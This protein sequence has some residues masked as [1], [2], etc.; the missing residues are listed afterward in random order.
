MPAWGTLWATYRFRAA[1]A[2]DLAVGLTTRAIRTWLPPLAPWPLTLLD[3]AVERR[4]LPDAWGLG[5]V[6]TLAD[7]RLTPRVSYLAG[8]LSERGWW[9]YFPATLALK[10]PLT[11]LL[12]AALGI[13]TLIRKPRG[14]RVPAAAAPD[15]SARRWAAIL[16]GGLPLALLGVAATS[17][18]DLGLRQVLPVYPFLLILAGGG[19]AACLRLWRP[20]GAA[21]A[22]AMIAW[23]SASSARVAPDYLAYF[24]EVAGGPDQGLRWLADSNLDWGQALRRLP[25]WL[26]RRGIREVN[27]CYFG[28]A[29]PDAYGIPHTPLPG[30]TT[31]V[32]PVSPPRLPGYV[33]ISATH[34]A[35]VHHSPEL[36]AWYRALLARGQL[37][38]VVGHAIHVYEVPA[39]P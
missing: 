34:L 9:Y 17:S 38:G 20:L 39:A 18:L 13:A 23:T 27:L 32:R 28:T 26:E 12:L 31:Y 16:I 37:V 3:G 7:A 33:A 15:G 25:A 2:P 1:A 4:L 36:R 6:Y 19:V 8:E 11:T 5:L 21:L 22:L 35:G 29:D 30:G 14:E 10:V 24:N